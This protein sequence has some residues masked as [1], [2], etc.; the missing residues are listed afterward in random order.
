MKFKSINYSQ[1]WEDSRVLL[2]ALQISQ[3]DVVLSI[4][5]GGDNTL[6][7]LTQKPE[8][9]VSVD[10]NNSQNYLLELKLAAIK[11]LNYQDF[12]EFLGVKDSSQRTEL[13]KRIQESLSFEA[14]Q[15]WQDHVCLIEKGV[16]NSGRFEKFLQ[17]FAKFVLP[18][19]HSKKTVYEFLNISDLSQQ[20]NFYNH[21]WN[22]W[23]W[24]F[25]F[26]VFSSRIILKKFARQ[27]GIFKYADE[28]DVGKIYFQRFQKNLQNISVKDNYFVRYCFTGLYDLSS[29]PPYLE[30]KNKD[31]LKDSKTPIDIV[32]DSVFEYLKKTPD[33]YFSKFNLSDIF[34]SLSNEENNDL[35]AEIM[36]TAKNNAVVT[37]WNNL[38]E[39]KYPDYLSKNI[40]DDKNTAERLCKADRAPFYGNFYINKIVK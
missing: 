11:K 28:P 26:K 13:F 6:A 22:N 16:I 25:F 10:L 14:R 19:I 5:S 9:V 21:T 7:I 3:N 33:N 36:R 27:K 31:L 8:K 17:I 39:R 24:G 29:L 34:E 37:Y 20:R 38:V 18:A 1:C 4:T 35:W 30:D 15:W 32:T 40:S 23:R 2:S 12:L